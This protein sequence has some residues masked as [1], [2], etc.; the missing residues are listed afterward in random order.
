[1]VLTRRQRIMGAV[2]AAIVLAAALPVNADWAEGVAAFQNKDYRTAIT[3]FDKVIER[4]PDYAGAY[5]MKGLAQRRLGQTSQALA[6]L[7]KAVLCQAS[8]WT[9]PMRFT[10]MIWPG[11][12]P[13]AAAGMSAPWPESRS[14]CALS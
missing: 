5:Y 8:S 3:E 10:G 11:R 9:L 12:S 13:G 1:M 2:A 6:N 7:R 4:A 14:A